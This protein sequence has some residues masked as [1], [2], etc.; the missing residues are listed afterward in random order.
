MKLLRT[1]SPLKLH[2]IKSTDSTWGSSMKLKALLE[3]LILSH[4]RR[5]T[6]SISNMKLIILGIRDLFVL[7]QFNHRRVKKTKRTQK[8]NL[9]GSFRLHYNWCSSSSNVA[10]ELPPKYGNTAVAVKDPLELSGYLHWLDETR[11]ADE[12]NEIDKLADMFI[13]NCHEKFMLEKQE[14]YRLFQEMMARSI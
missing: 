8:I 4:I 11:E 5:A 2:Q 9:H 14:S 1:P 6:H 3:A 13:A 7:G 12:A 10:P